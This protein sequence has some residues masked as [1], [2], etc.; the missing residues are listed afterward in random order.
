M[1][2]IIRIKFTHESWSAKR[3]RVGSFAAFCR[4][5]N[6][7]NRARRTHAGRAV[8]QVTSF[9]LQGATA[10]Q[11]RTG[12]RPGQSAVDLQRQRRGSRPRLGRNVAT[13]VVAAASVRAENSCGWHDPKAATM[14][15][16]AT[17]EAPPLPLAS[18]VLGCAARTP[19]M[20][21]ENCPDLVGLSRGKNWQ[22][23]THALTSL[24]SQRCG[25]AHLDRTPSVAA[26]G[27]LRIAGGYR[28]VCPAF[29]AYKDS[30]TT[31]CY[32]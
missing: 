28:S 19:R 32:L 12:F 30:L 3:A 9:G 4:P 15:V 2:E 14:F 13:A 8:W 10:R 27:S 16:A 22:P 20:E 23:L 1:F 6:Q 5:A 29:T 25:V 18:R 21:E 31:L 24:N 11:P 7:N 17:R 26:T